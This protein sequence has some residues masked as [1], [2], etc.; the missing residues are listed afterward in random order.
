IDGRFRLALLSGDYPNDGSGQRDG[1][2]KEFL[3]H[4]VCLPSASVPQQ[5]TVAGRWGEVSSYSCGGGPRRARLNN[6]SGWKTCVTTMRLARFDG[7]RL[8]LVDGTTLRDVTAALDALPSHRYP[9][10]THDVMIAD[11]ES[12]AARAREIGGP[13]MALV[14][15]RLLSPVA[16]PGKVI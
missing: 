15:A 9:L 14:E 13:S 8:G 16:N 12:I 5:Y 2:K 10:P 4:K 6:L 3:G 1:R 11:L 7:N